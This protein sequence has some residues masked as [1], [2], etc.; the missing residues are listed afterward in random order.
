MAADPYAEL[1]G[2]LT[3]YEAERLA[4]ALRA[5]DTIAQ[6]VKE[7]HASR[8]G[9]A[10]RLLAEADLG[11][12][13]VET[14]VALLHAIAGA[15]AVRAVITPVWTMPGTE[16]TV[17]RLTGETQRLID[18]ARMSVVCSSFNFTPHSGMWTALRAASLRPG[19]S[20]T[21]YLDAQAGAPSDV[22]AH[23]PK[24]TVYRTRTMPGADRP[25]VS[26]AKFIVLD[27]ALTLLTSAN[28][29]HSAEN[30]NIELGLLV[31]DSALAASIE[32]LMRSKHGVLYEQ[33][34][35]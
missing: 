30:T 31:N 23:L 29:S 32:S 2:F 18:E 33:V 22:A 10:K 35:A 1:G 20:I 8:R 6:A 27:R 16:A 12:H 21:I 3:A 26:H 11:P 4:G 34:T 19:V 7:V 17:G 15:R 13:R 9:E 5:G 14:S 28:F 25:L 24:A